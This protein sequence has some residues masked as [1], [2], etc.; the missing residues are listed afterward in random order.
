MKPSI[1][2]PSPPKL[3]LYPLVIPSFCPS[4]PYSV[5]QAINDNC[6]H[7]NLDFLELYMGRI[8]QCIPFHYDTSLRD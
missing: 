8:I 6:C 7:Y 4:H 3:P 2:Y 1:D 5:P